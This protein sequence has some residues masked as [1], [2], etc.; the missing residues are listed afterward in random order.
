MNDQCQK[1]TLRLYS[2]TMLDD[3]LREILPDS[4]Q[5]FSF[6]CIMKSIVIK[7]NMRRYIDKDKPVDM[8]DRR[9]GYAWHN[10]VFY[11]RM[12]GWSRY[13]KIMGRIT[14]AGILH[15]RII[16]SC[17]GRHPTYHVSDPKLLL[18]F[19]LYPVTMPRVYDKLCNYYRWHNNLQDAVI[20]KVKKHMVSFLGKVDLT[21]DQ[22][23]ELIKYRYFNHYLKK[24]GKRLS[25]EAYR[26]SAKYC[27][28]IILCWNR[29]S[30]E[31]RMAM[32]KT[33]IF[34][35]RLH[36]PF[37]FLPKEIRPFL[38]DINGE[39][40]RWLCFDL[41]NSQPLLVADMLVRLDPSLRNELFVQL[42]EDNSIYEHY[43]NVIGTEDRE[44]GKTEL[45]HGFYGVPGYDAHN[46]FE[47]TYGRAGKLIGEMKRKETDADGN[48]VPWYDRYIELPKN[49]QR[50]EST[51]FRTL[52]DKLID[53][54]FQIMPVHDAVYVNSNVCD[55]GQ[56]AEVVIRNHISNQIRLKNSVKIDPVR[57]YNNSYGF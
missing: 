45:M 49:M 32:M 48:H 20:Q 17:K 52:W 24:P 35:N 33:C 55:S 5:R 22:Y 39:K 41:A 29:S 26:G 15:E 7:T 11:A 37:T 40:I 6:Q 25:L 36:H 10:A 30:A 43:A 51:I 54:G 47:D 38:L 16:K 56:K 21:K 53:Q 23:D 28:Q 46:L 3:P 19:D 42:V 18:G 8:I 9:D 44:I 2:H 57:R 14:E 1:S 27:W 13:K 4:N 34:G 50:H 31:E 12:L